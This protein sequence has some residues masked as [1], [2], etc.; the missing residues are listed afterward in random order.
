MDKH[1][2]YLDKLR[3][4][5]ALGERVED[6]VSD[7]ISK[8]EQLKLRSAEKTAPGWLR[9]AVNYLLFLGYIVIAGI[10]ITTNLSQRIAFLH[11]DRSATI[12][13][14][15]VFLI[16]GFLIYVKIRSVIV[17]FLFPKINK[18][19]IKTIYKFA[20][21][22]RKD[23][24][25]QEAQIRLNKNSVVNYLILFCFTI[26]ITIPLFAKPEILNFI[27]GIFAEN[28]VTALM[29]RV[30]LIG[31]VIGIYLSMR[32][33]IAVHKEYDHLAELLWKVQKIPIKIRDREFLEACIPEKKDS[34]IGEKVKAV[35]R[36]L[37][38]KGRIMP[39]DLRDHTFSYYQLSRTFATYIVSVMPVL[40]LIGTVL[41]LSIAIG[42][43]E[44]VV[45][46]AGVD[47]DSFT[48]SL[49]VSIKGIGTAF[50]T[51]LG[52]TVCMIVLRFFNMIADNARM[53]FVVDM[54]NIIAIEILPRLVRKKKP[55]HE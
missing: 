32:N 9:M 50:Y 10:I 17:D 15:I 8:E 41:G 16:I 19:I 30:I 23:E 48:E 7:V 1:Q 27:F 36:I 14:K 37:A 2:K 31:F 20:P 43:L 3:E 52:G 45:S 28:G 53:N 39:E 18:E 5:I 25:E 51:T 33:L 22:V 11:G 35:I 49:G 24:L 46:L 34:I 12:I 55:H 29:I 4:S 6:M 26:L 40:G 13:F 44:G 21:E 38:I 47:Q 54:N 42:G